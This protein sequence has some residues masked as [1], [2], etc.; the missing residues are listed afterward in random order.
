MAT[1]GRSPVSP[2]WNTRPRN[3][4]IDNVS[5]NAGPTAFQRELSLVSGDDS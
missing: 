4:G 1:S 5:K 3:N 2:G